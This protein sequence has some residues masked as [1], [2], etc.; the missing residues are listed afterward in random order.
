MRQ[1]D[2]NRP[3]RTREPAARLRDGYFRV[4]PRTRFGVALA[5]LAAAAA[6]AI[7]AHWSIFSTVATVAIVLAIIAGAV[8]DPRI[9][10]TGLVVLGWLYVAAYGLARVYP[11]PQQAIA[12]LVLVALPVALVAHR[13]RML[14]PWR[15]AFFALLWAGLVGVGIGHVVPQLNALPVW[16]A[17]A[18]V[19]GWRWFSGRRLAR[20]AGDGEPAEQ[21]RLREHERGH[22][23]AERPAGQVEPPPEISLEDALA[24]LENM[25]GLEP[26]KEQVRSIAASIEAARMRAQA[27]YSTDKPMRHFVFVGP[28]GPARPRSPG[29]SA[30]SSTPTACSTPRTWSR[31][32]A[33]IWSASSS[34]PPRSRRTRWWIPR[35][36]K[37]VV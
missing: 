16:V 34:A 27:G 6:L 17:A 20:A 14:V 24:D 31:P 30:R 8:R 9:V 15:T 35:D 11:D 37:S 21:A 29:C 7:V 18:V 26:V 4:P 12:P 28:P 13:I 32:A 23:V 19:L 22:P 25:I 3:G 33:P 5:V 36:R 10:P 1:H 2:R